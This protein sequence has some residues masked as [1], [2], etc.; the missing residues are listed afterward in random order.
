MEKGIAGNQRGTV[1]VTFTL[2]LMVLLGFVALAIEVGDWYVTRAELSKAVDAAALA[3]ATNIASP[4]LNLVALAQD[5]G[6]AN[7]A[8]GYIGTPVSGGGA[9]SYAATATT[10]QMTVTGSVSAVGLIASLFG[11]TTIPISSTGAAQKNE[12]EIML[13]FDCSGSMAGTPISNLK[14]AATNFLSYFEP[15]QS[16]DM[17]GLVT[18]ATAATVKVPLETNFASAIQSVI[19]SLSANGGT[20]S[21]DAVADAGAQLPVQ[22][23]TPNADWKQ[24]FIVF[25]T[26]GEPT[27]FTSTFKHANAS[28]NYVVCTSTQGTNQWYDVY[29]YL[30][31][32]TTGKFGNVNPVQTG[33]GQNEST[34]VVKQGMTTTYSTSWA[35]PFAAYPPATYAPAP[36]PYTTAGYCDI[37]Q[38]NPG[39]RTTLATYVHNVAEQMALNNGASLKARGVMIYTIGLE[40]DG[41]IDTTFLSNLS[42]GPSFAYVAPDSSQLSAIFSQIAKD[43]SLRLVQ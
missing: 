38:G 5:F 33:L 8:P 28:A 14:T 29:P 34:C 19:N 11:V 26:D 10:D 36:D 40:G 35:T 32:P 2:L 39:P 25:F 16:E 18:F 24:Q 37:P 15:S 27:C 41:G 9:A 1:L 4:N 23:G 7:F 3:G 42:S 22:T 13:I 6:D 21:A 31:D 20:N 30:A 17:M 43:I 12:V